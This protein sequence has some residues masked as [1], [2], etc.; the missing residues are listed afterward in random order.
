[1]S[2]EKTTPDTEGQPAAPAAPE[3]PAPSIEE[4]MAAAITEG[5]ALGDAPDGGETPAAADP[6]TPPPA[7]DGGEAPAPDGGDPAAP[8]P[9]EAPDAATEIKA[10]GIKNERAQ[11]RFTELREKA[12]KL[13]EIEVTLPDL[14]SK[15]ET[16]EQML[17]HI[18]ETGATPQQYGNVLGYLRVVNKG[19]P[20]ELATAR[21]TLLK[22]VE[23]ID[24]KLG[25]GADP[26]ADH[27]DLREA[28]ANGDLSAAYAAEIANTRNLQAA[29]Q[30][31][32]QQ[33]N[34]Q[35][36]QAEQQRQ[37]ELNGAV[38]ELNALGARLQ[39]SDPLYAQK[40]EAAKAAFMQRRD[41]LPP[42]KWATELL[43]DYNAVV[44]APAAP[45]APARP[46][47]GAVPLRPQGGSGGMAKVAGSME[48]AIQLGLQAHAQG[49]A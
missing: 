2:T 35:Q 16:Y 47:V 11:Q 40:I 45:A 19:S 36:S 21:E 8:A 22:E 18:E 12:S 42:S 4:G 13:D 20:A 48:E 9:A 27:A 10:L 37:A 30:R 33:T 29:Q 14:Q 46:A 5:L 1:M 34:E 3:T 24:Q 44:I 15:A 49:R 28:V 17:T 38:Q 23:F 41:S 7:G 39:A 25:R 6:E 26:L 32:V 43:L 31:H